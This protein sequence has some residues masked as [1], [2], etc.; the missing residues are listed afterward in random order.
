MLLKVGFGNQLIASVKLDDL[1]ELQKR[2]EDR[3]RSTFVKPIKSAFDQRE[4]KLRIEAPDFS[5]MDYDKK[6]Q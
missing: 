4:L 6:L 3:Q 5:C 2:Q 1:K